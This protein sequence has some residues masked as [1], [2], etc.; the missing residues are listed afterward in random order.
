MREPGTNHFPPAQLALYARGDLGFWSRLG[1]E[2]HLRR[3]GECADLAVEFSRLQEVIVDAAADL[4]SELNGPAWHRLASEMTANIRLAIA[5]GECVTPRFISQARPRLTLA[6]A[7][8]AVLLVWAGLERPAV[9]PGTTQ[10]NAETGAESSATP[11]LE[12]SESG[13]AVRGSGRAFTVAAPAGQNTIRTVSA[14]GEIRSRYVDDT[15][16]TIVNVYA[17]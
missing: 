17:E 15:G 8:L 7:G 11:T 14:R 10:L 13:I 4:P 12:G 2:R 1:V 5:A 3:C 6:L 16:V 9:F